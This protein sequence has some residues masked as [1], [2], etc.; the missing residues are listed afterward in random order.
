MSHESRLKS[1]GIEL[2]EATKP[3]ANYVPAKRAGS[4]LFLSGQL[5]M[6]NG[7]LMAE[8]KV[9][10]EVS[11][12]TAKACAK[13]CMI[14][15]LAAMKA[16]LG[17]LDEIVQIVKL[18]GFVASAPGFTNQPAVINGASDFLVEVFGDAGKH[19]RSAVGLSELPRNAPVEVELIVEI[20]QMMIG[21][22][23]K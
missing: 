14:A 4:L 16:E 13:Q 19:A 10:V 5:P 7:K 11:E 9:G 1:L 15:G 23:N 8:G 21:L 12:E 2:P 20:R 6:L 17:S 3:L 22:G 18:T